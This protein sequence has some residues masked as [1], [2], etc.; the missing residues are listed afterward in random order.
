MAERIRGGTSYQQLLGAGMLGGVR[1]IRTR[2]VG[3]QLHAVLVVNSAHLAAQAARDQD[4]WLPLFWAIDNFKSSQAR[5][6]QV[7]D[8]VMP[9]VEDA[10]L[11]GAAQAAQRFRD[12]MDNW[13]EAGDDRAVAAL[14]RT[15]GA[16]E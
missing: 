16:N 10:Q 6:R 14:A 2:P 4:R 5:N 11:P 15:A 3:F 8:W 1:G 7:G 13:D 9:P 12:A